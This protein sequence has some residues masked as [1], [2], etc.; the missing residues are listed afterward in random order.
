MR[1]EIV[2]K[3]WTL[4]DHGFTEKDGGEEMILKEVKCIHQ[5]MEK[6]TKQRDDKVE[7]LVNGRVDP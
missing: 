4:M 5:D 3:Y 7:Q 2:N 1:L 6:E